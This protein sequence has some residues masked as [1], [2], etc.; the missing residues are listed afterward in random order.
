MSVIL[1]LQEYLARLGIDSGPRVVPAPGLAHGASYQTLEQDISQLYNR[2][3]GA[4]EAGA[5]AMS[6]RNSMVSGG[7]SVYARSGHPLSVTGSL[8]RWVH[9]SS[10]SSFNNLRFIFRLTK[11]E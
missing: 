4:E 7:N 6:D 1:Y 8:S 3:T 11:S 5:G 2:L 10:F 9:S